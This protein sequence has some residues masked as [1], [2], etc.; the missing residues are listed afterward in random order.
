MDELRWPTTINAGMVT[1]ALL[2]PDRM[3]TVDLFQYIRHLETNKQNS[4]MY[5]IQFWKKCFTP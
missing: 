3:G 5:E 2:K 4:Q 1:T